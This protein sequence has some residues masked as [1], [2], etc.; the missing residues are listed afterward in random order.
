MLNHL[1]SLLQNYNSIHPEEIISKEKM[2][3]FLDNF[4]YSNDLENWNVKRG[5]STHSLYLIGEHTSSLKFCRANSSNHLSM[6]HFTA[7]AFLLNHDQTK[8]L[9]MHHKKLNKW[10]QL[11]GHCESDDILTEAIREAREESGINEIEAVSNNIF[12][13]DVH[14]IPQ[15]PKEPSHYHYDIRFLLKT[16]NN[17]NFIKN[18]ESHELKWFSFSDYPQL[19]VELERSVTRMIEKFKNV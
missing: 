14:Y 15:T 3:E 5:A 1:K 6:G 2:L 9:L 18:N 19:G 10:L 4:T 12:D 13:I 8:F 16:I 7:S 11:G 17:D